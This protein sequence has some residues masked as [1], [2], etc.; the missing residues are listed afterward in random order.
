MPWWSLVTLTVVVVSL[1]K[2]RGGWV[3]WLLLLPTPLFFILT[4]SLIASFPLFPLFRFQGSLLPY[5]SSPPLPSLFSF[6]CCCDVMLS[7][8][9]FTFLLLMFLMRVR[10][11]CQKHVI[12]SLEI[13]LSAHGCSVC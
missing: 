12:V 1:K 10:F 7:L 13:V 2:T 11:S 9:L 4:L 6:L 3:P 8:I 5:S